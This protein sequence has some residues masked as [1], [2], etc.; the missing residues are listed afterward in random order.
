MLP[1]WAFTK[2]K[3]GIDF[4]WHIFIWWLMQSNVDSGSIEETGRPAPWISSYSIHQRAHHLSQSVLL[5]MCGFTGSVATDAVESVNRVKSFVKEKLLTSCFELKRGRCANI[6]I[7]LNHFSFFFPGLRVK[8]SKTILLVEFFVATLSWMFG[9][10]NLLTYQSG[11]NDVYFSKIS[12]FIGLCKT[13]EIFHVH[14]L[15]QGVN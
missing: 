6:W 8:M 3:K 14:N 10:K 4:M 11:Q 5:T 13:A 9:L 2:T 15:P 1:C 7:E 12:L